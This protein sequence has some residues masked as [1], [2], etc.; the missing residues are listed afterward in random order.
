M[1]E[2]QRAVSRR[3]AEL[4][5]N[6]A[7][8]VCTGAAT[9]LFLTTLAC[10]TRGR[11]E[12]LAALPEIDGLQDEVIIHRAQR[13]TYDP[14]V[15]MTRSRF[16]EIGMLE[17]TA[18]WELE[19]AITP[20]TAAVL[21]VAVAGSHFTRGA[22]SLDEVIQTAHEHDV[23]VIV[24]AAAQLPPVEN[25]WHYTRDLGA[26]LAIFSGGKDLRGP[27]ASG[28]IVGR[29][30]L[31]AACAA[32]GTPNP[33]IGRPMKV[34]KEEM[35]GLLAAIEGYLNADHAA[36]DAALEDIVA[37]WVRAFDGLPGVRARRDFPNEAGQ[38]MPRCLIELDPAAGLDGNAVRRRL[39][40]GDPRIAVQNA[41]A[42]GLHVTA[43]ALDPEPRG[44]Y[45]T[46]DCL[47]PGEEHVVAER[48]LEVL[49]T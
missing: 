7:A 47:A 15:R 19:E 16:V 12:A 41:G 48:V 2:L 22:L 6:E 35:I 32:A 18:L 42:L 17:G 37:G 5:G 33:Y 31:V 9:G 30:D 23:P 34:G 27:Q 46:A 36:R 43:D 1:F 10:M 26:D 3:I 4:T 21:Y 45:L 29:A 8:Y 40:D 28:L 13:F 20:R 49:R 25:L 38:P 11:P 14:A 39:W 24:D 44:I